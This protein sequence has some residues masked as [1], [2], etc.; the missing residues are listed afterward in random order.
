MCTGEEGTGIGKVV[1]E[2]AKGWVVRI[3]VHQFCHYEEEK[4]QKVRRGAEGF[5]IIKE[6]EGDTY[7]TNPLYLYHFPLRSSY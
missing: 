1:Y 3:T 5:I 2:K 4:E 6:G 7:Y